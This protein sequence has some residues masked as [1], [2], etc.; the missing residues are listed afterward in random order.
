VG[1]CLL[2]VDQRPGS[3]EQ[4]ELRLGLL[5]DAPPSHVHRKSTAAWARYQP[6]H[7]LA[8][9]LWRIKHPEGLKEFTPRLGTRAGIRSGAVSQNATAPS[10]RRWTCR[11]VRH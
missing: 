5:E 1:L 2:Q 8:M 4:V 3:A 10:G 11:P 7:A 9:A 6:A